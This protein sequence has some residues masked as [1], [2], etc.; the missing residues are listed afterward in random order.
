MCANVKNKYGVNVL[1]KDVEGY[2]KR[3]CSK[4]GMLCYKFNSPGRTGVPDRIIVFAGMIFFVECKA[5]AGKLTPNQV[6]NHAELF[7]QGVTVC[8]VKS[9]FEVDTLLSGIKKLLN[10]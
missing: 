1:E 7:K 10:A 2:L 3:Q 4:H 9:F 5:P 8:V 6:A